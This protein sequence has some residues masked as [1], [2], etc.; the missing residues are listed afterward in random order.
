[1]RYLGC[2]GAQ[3][4]VQQPRPMITQNLCGSLNVKYICLFTHSTFCIL[5]VQHSNQI[6]KSPYRD[7]PL[8]FIQPSPVVATTFHDFYHFL[9]PQGTSGMADYVCDRKVNLWLQTQSE[10]KLMAYDPLGHIQGAAKKYLH[11]VFCPFL[12]QLP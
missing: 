8:T 3:F 2:L 9:Y 5:T 10:S 4:Y 7:N 6:W 11:N 1:M 12:T